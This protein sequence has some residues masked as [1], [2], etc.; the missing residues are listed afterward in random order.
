[1]G[2]AL[3][4]GNVV[5]VN[6]KRIYPNGSDG[7]CKCA[8]AT[9][10]TLEV[11]VRGSAASAA[12]LATQCELQVSPGQIVTLRLP[13]KGIHDLTLDHSGN[14]CIK[15][16]VEVQVSGSVGGSVT[17]TSGDVKVETNVGGDVRST[18]GNI[19][20]GGNVDGACQSTSGNIKVSGNVGGSCS[21]TSGDISA[22]EIADNARTVSG[23]IDR[24][25][26]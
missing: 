26:R 1:M 12:V 2:N 18:S 11:V 7:N 4:D 19:E 3:S 9:K 16:N 22:R 14:G 15:G 10:I 8:G 6:G 23:D 20:C 13:K 17:T 25:F 5:F 21:S 24:I